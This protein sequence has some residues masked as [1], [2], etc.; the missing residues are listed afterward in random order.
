M[1]RNDSVSGI[2]NDNYR[3]NPFW[4]NAGKKDEKEDRE[5]DK[6]SKKQR[7]PKDSK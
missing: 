7:K 5:S 3:S 1:S 6:K 4:D 2:P